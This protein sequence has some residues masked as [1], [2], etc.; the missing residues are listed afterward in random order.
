MANLCTLQNRRLQDLATLMYKVKHNI[1]PKYVADLFQRSEAKYALRN[2]EFAI[3]RFKTVT[4][5]KHRIRYTEPK[6]WNIIPKDIRSLPTLSSF[7]KTIRK[8]DLDI[9]MNDNCCANCGSITAIS[10]FLTLK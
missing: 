3:P 9:L 10:V 7:K 1:C 4:Y 6:I 5:G 8:L 2:K